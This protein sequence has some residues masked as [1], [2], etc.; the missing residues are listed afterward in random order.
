MVLKVLL[1]DDEPIILKNLTQIINWRDL[2]CEV[3]GAAQ[4]GQ[5]ALFFMEKESID[6]LV[7]DIS[8]PGMT[9]IELIKKINASKNKPITILISGYD[10]FEY[11]LEG[12]RNN[13]LDYILKPIDYDELQA[14]VEKAIKKIAEERRSEYEQDKFTIYKLV[15]EEK[16]ESEINNK[17]NAYLAI[18]IKTQEAIIESRMFESQSNYFHKCTKLYHYKMADDLVYLIVECCQDKKEQVLEQA[19]AFAQNLAD[20]RTVKSTFAIGSVVDCLFDIIHSVQ[21]AKELIKF[22]HCMDDNVLT[23]DCLK[24]NYKAKHNSLD[25]MEE[26]FYYIKNN[27]QKDL[28]MEMIAEKVDLSVS[29]FSLLFKQKTGT[30][31]LDYLTNLR[32]DYACLLLEKSDMK[33]YEIA[34]K[35]GYTDQRY[36]SQ[37]FKKKVKKTPSEYRKTKSR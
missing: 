24:E 2:G 10:D 8:M 25:S 16:L 20:G 35:V 21:S 26:A 37:V 5:E 15:M 11:A 34:Q 27:F 19:A 7:T 32:M 23:E 1:A 9:G 22:E 13:A 18:I 12:I 29:Y 4:N 3:S 36:F 31:F 33:T 28:S 14:C 6:I 17:Y 30:T